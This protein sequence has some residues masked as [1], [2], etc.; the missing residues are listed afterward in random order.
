MVTLSDVAR[1]AGVSAATASRVINGTPYTIAPE[2]RE[3]VLAAVRELR[4]VPNAH[5]QALA[6]STAGV[7]GVIVH[8]VSDP[9]FAEITRGLQRVA[10]AHDRLVTI[11]NS[12]RAPQRELDYLALLRGQRVDG[13]VYTGSGYLDA[14]FNAALEEQL[15]ALVDDGARVVLLAR[16][17]LSRRDDIDVLLPD[18]AGG[19]A[20]L[21]AHVAGAGHR[22]VGV[23]AGPRELHTTDDRLRGLREGLAVG[24]VTLDERRV[25]HGDFARAGGADGVRALLRDDADLTAVIALNDAMAVGA[26]RELRRL[27]L[28]VPDD[29]SLAGFDDMPVAQ[30]VTPPLTTVRIPLVELGVRA[31]TLVLEDDRGRPRPAR[32]EAVPATLVVRDSIGPPRGSPLR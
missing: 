7:I 23:I 10:T 32:R 11:C 3:R 16:H 12:Y 4:Y 14:D 25:V 5:A 29:L 1:R 31:M 24:G 28:R 18:N 20:A 8:D 26:L 2:L 22:R 9:Y 27:G 30:D 6:G 15:R 21:G 17:D 19:A 13:L